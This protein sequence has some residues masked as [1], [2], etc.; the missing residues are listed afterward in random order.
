[1]RAI[2]AAGLVAAGVLLAAVWLAWAPPASAQM[3]L[4]GVNVEGEAEAGVRLYIDRPSPSRRAKFEEYRDLTPGPFLYDLRLRV[5][6]DDEAYSLDFGGSKWGYEDQ[7]FSLGVGRLG[8]WEFGFEWDQTP[9]ILST[10]ARTRAVEVGR[11]E[12][13]LP[14]RPNATSIS[15]AEGALYNNAPEIGEVGV[16]WDTAR[17]SLLLTPFPDLD[18]RADY[19]R[20][21]KDGDRPF[22]V[23]MGSPGNDFIEVLRPIEET[24][25]DFRLRGTV[26]RETWQ[27][28]FGYTFSMF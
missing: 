15:A 27:L 16:R 14:A 4:G 26:A 19:T 2:R 3:R 10:T 7:E 20:I 8:L 25:H 24:I 21:Y 11:G 1:M 18:L 12:W 13:R 17:I 9:H 28:T 5:F 23:A 22:G 6:T